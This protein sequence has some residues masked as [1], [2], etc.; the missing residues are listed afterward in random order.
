MLYQIVRITIESVWF[1]LFRKHYVEY[2]VVL[3]NDN[4]LDPA[5]IMS[6]ADL[7]RVLE[8]GFVNPPVEPNG[9]NDQQYRQ[10]LLRVSG[11]TLLTVTCD[12][13]LFSFLFA[14]HSHEKHKNNQGLDCNIRGHVWAV[15]GLGLMTGYLIC[16]DLSFTIETRAKIHEVKGSNVVYHLLSILILIWNVLP[17][18]WTATLQCKIILQPLATHIMDWLFAWQ[19]WTPGWLSKSVFIYWY[20]NRLGVQN[21]DPLTSPLQENK[22]TSSN[23]LCWIEQLQATVLKMS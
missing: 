11:I 17:S 8:R 12:R 23:F 22:T 2:L 6:P 15:P 4:L 1:S 18:F 20:L 13:P 7:T 9:M 16:K 14:N 21:I 5:D 19:T 3:V 10:L